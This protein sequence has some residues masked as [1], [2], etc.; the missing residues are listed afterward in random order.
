M[1]EIKNIS[2]VDILLKDSLNKGIKFNEF[3][4]PINFSLIGPYQNL[5]QFLQLAEN[6]IRPIKIDSLI[7]NSSNTVDNIKVIVLTVGGKVPYA[8]K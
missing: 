1:I 7:F 4:L 2:S 8:Q 5:F 3:E 6:L